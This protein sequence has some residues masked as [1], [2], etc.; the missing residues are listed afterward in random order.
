MNPRRFVFYVLN[1]AYTASHF[2]SLAPVRA[3]DEGRQLPEGYRGIHTQVNDN[4]IRAARVS[5]EF[6]MDMSWS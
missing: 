3:I 1:R 6:E 4:T 5:S 2:V